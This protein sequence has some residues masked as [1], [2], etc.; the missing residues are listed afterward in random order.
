MC[1]PGSALAAPRSIMVDALIETLWTAATA[2][3][4]KTVHGYCAASD[5][6]WERMPWP[7]P[8]LPTAYCADLVC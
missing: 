1:S 2:T 7:L 5:R 6:R 4:R 8:G 3:A